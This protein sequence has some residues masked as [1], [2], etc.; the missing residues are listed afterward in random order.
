MEIKLTNKSK[1]KKNLAVQI[2][3][4][5]AK[6]RPKIRFFTIFLSVVHLFFCNLHRVSKTF[7]TSVSKTYKKSFVVPN[8]GQIDQN[9]LQI[10]FFL[11]HFLNS[12]SLMIAWNSVSL[13]VY[14]KRANSGPKLGLLPIFWSLVLLF[15]L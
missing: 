9:W 4:K 3:A 7:Y 1:S 8:L 2:K 5:R 14:L 13:L 12:G 10:C 11:C 6:V 15:F